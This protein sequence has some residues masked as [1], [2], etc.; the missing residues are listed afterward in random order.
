MMQRDAQ[1][2]CVSHSILSHN[3]TLVTL[4][5][6]SSDQVMFIYQMT[7]SKFLR[8]DYSEYHFEK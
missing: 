7:F 5:N 1:L 2:L 3:Q 6:T 4:Q 8:G